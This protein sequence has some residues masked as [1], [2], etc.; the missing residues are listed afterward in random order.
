MVKL[1]VIVAKANVERDSHV[2]AATLPRGPDRRSPRPHRGAP[3]RD[4]PGD[5]ITRQLK[6]IVGI[7]MPI[8]RIEGKWKV[9]QNKND[10]ERMGACRGLDFESGGVPSA[11]SKLVERYGPRG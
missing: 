10:Q 9:S 11:M 3:F 1:S 4:A 6:G 2:S 5:D 8:S 7:E